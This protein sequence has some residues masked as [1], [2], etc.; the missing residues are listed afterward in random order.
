MAE[1]SSLT[2]TNGLDV[3]DGTGRVSQGSQQSS[4]G[5]FLRFCGPEGIVYESIDD[6]IGLRL[7]LFCRS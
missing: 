3:K 1:G 2:R 5:S 4:L 7:F 6:Y